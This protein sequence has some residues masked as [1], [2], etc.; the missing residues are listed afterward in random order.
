MTDLR[1]MNVLRFG[2]I[3]YVG[4]HPVVQALDH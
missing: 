1:E 2:N 4:A 3:P